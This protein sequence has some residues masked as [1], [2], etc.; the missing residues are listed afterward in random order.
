MHGGYRKTSGINEDDVFLYIRT[1]GSHCD[2]HTSSFEPN[3][4]V[5]N[6]ANV[7]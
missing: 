4:L 2:V 6:L 3:W 1:I 5:N 7:F